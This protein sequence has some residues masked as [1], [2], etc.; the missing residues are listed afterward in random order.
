MILDHKAKLDWLGYVCD[1]ESQVLE[2]PD[3]KEYSKSSLASM[4]PFYLWLYILSPPNCT[5]T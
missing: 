3:A 2:N 5:T 1:A 4:A